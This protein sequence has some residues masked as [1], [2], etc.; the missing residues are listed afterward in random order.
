MARS[1]V[2]NP[3]SRWR[4]V[5]R[6]ALCRLA[7]FAIVVLVAGV[8]GYFVMIR[9]PGKSFEGPPPPL[10]AEQAQLRDELR[11]HVRALAGEIGPR[12][13][14]HPKSLARAEEYLAETLRT[15]G[16]EVRRQTYEAEGV[17]CS[18][19]IA[20]VPGVEAGGAMVI[21]GA[22]YDTCWTTPGADDNTSAVAA[23]LA[24]ARRFARTRPQRTLRFV[25]FVNEEPPF[26]RTR[27]MGS[28]V[29]AR[30]CAASNERIAAM[31]CL[32][33]LGYY[34]DGA[35]S[36]RYP[37]PGLGLAYPRRGDFIGFVSNLRS[38][39]LLRDV[40]GAFRRHA[41]IPSEGAALPGWA[42]GVG[43]SDHWS[44]WK[45]GYADRAI[46]VT[47]TAMFR[48]P[49]YH[50]PSDTPD[51]LDYARMARVVTGLEAVVR[52]LAEAGPGRDERND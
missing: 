36:Q 26:F 30:H 40:I 13:V 32:E 28:L 15:M 5:T 9:M 42:P 41:D 49:N 11:G 12:N 34:S 38:R 48:N 16:H 3:K 8:W 43:L 1:A 44:F 52:A 35:G 27:R 19:L 45:A 18:N 46:M 4:V 17:P 39:R 33:M 24:L 7:I 2:V 25:L 14:A 47:D 50:R 23:T 29:Y 51:T 21:V 31:I 37:L 20:E 10:T 6:R 22:H